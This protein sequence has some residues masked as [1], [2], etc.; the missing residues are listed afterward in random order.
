V[1]HSDA[2]T[3]VH[4]RGVLEEPDVVAVDGVRADPAVVPCP[5]RVGDRRTQ[6]GPDRTGPDRTGQV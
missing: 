4:D 6:S 2:V 5:L 1:D 3:L